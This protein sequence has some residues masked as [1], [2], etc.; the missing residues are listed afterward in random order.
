MSI[1]TFK[2]VTKIYSGRPIVSNVSFAIQKGERCGI[3]GPVGSGKTTL[4]NLTTGIITPD[5]GIVS[6]F[7]ASMANRP[8]PILQKINVASASSRLSGYSSVMENL[9]TYCRLYSVAR[10]M[11]KI[12]SLVRALKIRRLVFSGIKVYRLSTGEN[13]MINLCKALL[14]DPELLLLDE[15][16]SHLDPQS[17]K[18]VLLMIKQ[19]SVS[20]AVT[21]LFASQQVADVAF[22]CKRFLLLQGGKVIHDG[23]IVNKNTLTPLYVQR[24]K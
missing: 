24:E 12:E 3:L 18:T 2:N 1:I 13:L 4:L 20:R 11:E 21:I 16:T 9:L 23:T 17:T 19:L 22:L 10:P 15:I 14:N 7:G 8:L 6:V 5:R